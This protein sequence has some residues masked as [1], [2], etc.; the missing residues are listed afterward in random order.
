MAKLVDALDLG[1]SAV[2]RGGSIPFTRTKA[3]FL[4]GFCF[5]LEGP[6]YFL[7]CK[8][9]LVLATLAQLVEHRIRNA[10]VVGSSPMSG[11]YKDEGMLSVVLLKSYVALN[12][13]RD[14]K[15]KAEKLFNRIKKT[16]QQGKITKSDKLLTS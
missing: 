15:D 4:E 1:S 12:G 8:F 5:L 10:R 2:R 16:V 6:T 3:L 14:I 11:S 9:A 7:C 13:K